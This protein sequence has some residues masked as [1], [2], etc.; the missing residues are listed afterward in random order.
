MIED[1]ES[2]NLGREAARIVELS[3]QLRKDGYAV[4]VEPA[5]DQLPVFLRNSEYTPDLIATSPTGNIIAEV[6]SRS[7]IQGDR[8]TAEIADLVNQQEQ[9][10]FL[11]VYTN[12]RNPR[13]SGVR[14]FK[15]AN[16]QLVLERIDDVFGKLPELHDDIDRTSLFL[17][18]WVLLEAALNAHP[19]ALTSKKDSVSTY[20]LVRDARIAGWLSVKDFNKLNRSREF[21]NEIIHGDV[22][23]YVDTSQ[24]ERILGIAKNLLSNLRTTED[25]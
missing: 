24:I 22:S 1:T 16:V 9:W 18:S 17:Y 2:N 6:K 25:E 4:V 7:S 14:H 15:A 21:R 20:T 13:I 5:V 23:V 10:K 8:R 12:P 3:A 19:D 11:F